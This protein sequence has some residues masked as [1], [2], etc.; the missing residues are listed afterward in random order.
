M[1]GSIAAASLTHW[2]DI[3]TLLYQVNP[4][5][6]L[7]FVVASTGLTIIAVIACFWPAW[8]ASRTN[9]AQALRD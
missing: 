8:R 2:I 9:P 6:P 3:K 4:R 1:I 5:D 7:A